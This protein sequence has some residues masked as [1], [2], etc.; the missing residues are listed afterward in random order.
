MMADARQDLSGSDPGLRRHAVVLS[1]GGADGAYEVGVLKAVLGGASWVTGYV[2]LDP[3]IFTGTSI[4]S[5]N[6]AFLVSHWEKYSAETILQ[7]EKVWLERLAT[8]ASTCGN[9]IYRFRADPLTLFD[10]RCYLRSPMGPLINLAEDSAVLGWE[11]LQRAIH[12]LTSRG[13]AIEQRV[14]ESINLSSFV[15]RDPW[16]KTLRELIDYAAIRRSPKQL[17]IAATNWATGEL[18]IFKNY[19]MTAQLGPQAIL[20]S[21]ATPGFFQPAQVGSLPF[22]DGGVLL[23]TPL[24][25][26]ID[27]GA[28]VVQ[29]M[30]L[31][32]DIKSIPLS[33][34]ENTLETLY[35]MQQIQW[36]GSVNNDVEDAENIN[37]TLA[38]LGRVRTVRGEAEQP[39]AFF[40]AASKVA[41]RDFEEFPYRPLTIF[42]YHPRD[43]LGGSLGFLNLDRKR[44][45]ALIERGFEDA[46]HHDCAESGDVLPFP[47]DRQ[48]LRMDR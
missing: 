42:R 44:I 27:A 9:G 3:D 33:H 6:A 29:M 34:L 39:G 45:E 43:T 32:P 46:V 28:D 35:R 17:R 16:E 22:V 48:G 36:A 40:R 19:D 2:P 23:N 15:S 47:E 7:L 20:A 10:P 18:R 5:F 1:G 4:G 25:P 13:E 26:A 11:G 21:S 24:K 41:E 12:F 30:Y 37:K 8:S 14:V 31:D 38:I